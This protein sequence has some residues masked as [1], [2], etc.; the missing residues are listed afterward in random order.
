MIA[1][2]DAPKSPLVS[3]VL[4]TYNGST[5]LREQL[6]SLFAQTYP[7]IEIIAVD[8]RSSDNTVEILRE[9]ADRHPAMKVFV[10]EKNLGFIG[11]F[12]NGCRLANGDYIA[13]CDQD[14]YWHPDKIKKKMNAI[15]SYPMI[16]CDSRLCDGKLQYL[17]RNISDAAHNETFTDPRQLCVFSRM[18]G[19]TILI[20]RRLFELSNPF[21]RSMPH[22]GWLAYHATLYGG[23]KYL[24]EALVEYRQHESNVF[25]VVGGK[26]KK[27][28]E[29]R[30]EKKKREH[31]NARERMQAFYNACPESLTEQKQFLRKLLKSYQSFSIPNNFLRMSLFFANYKRLLIVK[32]YGTFR[33]LVFCL[34]TFAKIP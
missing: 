16:Y 33:K 34:K 2:I 32:K 14:D 11:N 26:S 9:Y 4:G 28:K 7:N 19:H 1:M 13:F 8:D 27:R 18:Y 3:I 17:G 15:G 6:D 24:P 12:E 23:V 25:G 21:L 5:Y 30:A 29:T 10:N 20:T 31:A 22:D